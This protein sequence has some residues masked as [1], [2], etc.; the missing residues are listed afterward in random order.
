MEDAY[1]LAR[2]GRNCG[3]YDRLCSLAEW[4]TPLPG[5]QL[6]WPARA[7]MEAAYVLARWGRDCADLSRM[8]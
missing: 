1:V 6:C 3:K 4:V 5:E 7:L 8:D 2:W